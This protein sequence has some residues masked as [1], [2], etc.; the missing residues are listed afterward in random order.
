MLLL[1]EYCCHKNPIICTTTLRALC[2]FMTT[3][4]Y[5]KQLLID[6]LVVL[7]SQIKNKTGFIQEIL[8]LI[9]FWLTNDENIN[10]KYINTL[11]DILIKIM[12]ENLDEWSVTL[13]HMKI[14]TNYDNHE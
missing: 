8:E 5:Q 10:Y 7:N 9:V 12:E 1:Q 11:I 3:N 4:S 13:F 2:I 14:N 6:W